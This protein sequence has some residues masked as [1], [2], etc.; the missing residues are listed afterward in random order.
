MCIGNV[1]KVKFTMMKVTRFVCESETVL[2]EILDMRVLWSLEIY[3][4]IV[5]QSPS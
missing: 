5:I 4:S 2:D 1:N 3:G